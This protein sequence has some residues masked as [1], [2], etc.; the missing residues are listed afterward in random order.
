M[1]RTIYLN[2]G[3]LQSFCVFCWFVWVFFLM[4]SGATTSA[5]ILL[6]SVLHT[7]VREGSHSYDK[8]Q[9]CN[10]IL[11]LVQ[12]CQLKL[13]ML[14]SSVLFIINITIRICVK[15]AKCPEIF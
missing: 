6:K 10:F 2:K 1:G 5:M 14:T 11:Q 4:D 9:V 15:T 13:L 3:D 7:K 8:S 12:L